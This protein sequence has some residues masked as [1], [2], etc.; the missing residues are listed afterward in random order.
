VRRRLD[1]ERDY[2]NYILNLARSARNKYR[3]TPVRRAHTVFTLAA[4]APTSAPT[5]TA[6]STASSPAPLGRAAL[7][8]PLVALPSLEGSP[9]RTVI[10]RSPT[11]PPSYAATPKAFPL[12]LA[13]CLLEFPLPPLPLV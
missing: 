11:L 4:S 2:Y 13:Y 8:R 1:R 9:V 5:S 7:P 6:A 10:R 3:S 12:H